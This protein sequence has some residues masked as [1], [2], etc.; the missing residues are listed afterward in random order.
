MPVQKSL[1]TY[2]K[3]LIIAQRMWT[4]RDEKDSGIVTWP[5]S[6]PTTDQ[7]KAIIYC[8][9]TQVLVNIQLPGGYERV[10]KF[11][12]SYLVE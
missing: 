2:W 5:Q 9:A 1:E 7:R 10:Q 11:I 3:H 4:K 6:D 8:P 12:G